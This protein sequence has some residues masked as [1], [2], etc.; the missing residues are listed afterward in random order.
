LLLWKSYSGRFVPPVRLP[1]DLPL[2]GHHPDVPVYTAAIDSHLKDTA[3]IVPS[4]GG[5]D[6]RL[7]GTNVCGLGGG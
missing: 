2:H 6:D 1:T 3:T 4:L 7:F 5:A